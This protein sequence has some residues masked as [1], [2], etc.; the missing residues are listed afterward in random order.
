[1]YTSGFALDETRTQSTGLHPVLS[2]R[3]QCAG[4]TLSR[5]ASRLPVR[6][7]LCFRN[8]ASYAADGDVNETVR[9]KCK[10]MRTVE[11][12]DAFH[13]RALRFFD[14]LPTGA[15]GATDTKS[16]AAACESCPR[17]LTAPGIIS[18]C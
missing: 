18:T 7:S 8:R 3:R 11:R 14:Y 1:M 10:S 16:A 13:H 12:L 17:D 2:S 4:V 6:T 15:V 9:D 5:R